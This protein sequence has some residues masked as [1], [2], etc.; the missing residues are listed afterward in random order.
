MYYTVY[1][2]TNTLNSLCLSGGMADT[3]HLECSARAW[4]FESLL[5]YQVAIIAQLDRAPDF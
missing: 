3:L 1:K 2:I 4:G 5:R